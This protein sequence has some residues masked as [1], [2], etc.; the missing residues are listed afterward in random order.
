MA[1]RE[2]STDRADRLARLEAE[3]RRLRRLAAD[4]TAD[5]TERPEA[6]RSR[7]RD[8]AVDPAHRL[9]AGAPRQP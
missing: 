7:R 3:N 1:I 4:L 5:V 6:R 2:T 8:G 9:L